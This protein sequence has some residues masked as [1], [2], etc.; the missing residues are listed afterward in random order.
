MKILFVATQLYFPQLYGGVQTSTDQLCH[1]LIKRGHKVALLMKLMPGGLFGWRARAH[2]YINKK[3]VGCKVSKDTGYGYPIWRT[4]FPVEA[5]DYVSIKERPDLI[6]IMSGGNVMPLALKAKQTSIPILVQL[7]DVGLDEEYGESF[8]QLGNVPCIA[9]SHFTAERYHR[10]YGVSPSV[11]YPFVAI[12]R[13]QTP[14]TKE[15]ITFINPVSEKGC[16]IA[17]KIARLCPDISFSFVEGWTLS[18]EQRQLLDR[19]LSDLPN[20]TLLPSTPDMRLIYGKCKILLVPSTF[21]ETF[22]RVV[23]EAQ[24]SGI[25]VIASRRGGLPETVGPGGILLDP[26][27]PIEDWVKAVRKLWQDDQYYNELSTAA[28]AHAQRPDMNL[29]HQIDAYEKTFAQLIAGE[30]ELL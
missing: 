20:V 27:G 11:I 1:A 2:M 29:N 30:E 4:W 26:E 22:G 24:A 18:Q 6:I 10:V 5:L 7:H 8:R 28:L 13:Y 23:T 21:E 19:T 25:P 12:E 9:N 14:T 16:D 3:L 17:C 15:N